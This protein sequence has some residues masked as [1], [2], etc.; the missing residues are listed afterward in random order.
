MPDRRVKKF[1]KKYE[2]ENKVIEDNRKMFSPTKSMKR[3]FSRKKA[4]ATEDADTVEEKPVSE[5][6]VEEP[7]VEEPPEEEP[8]A[9]D[10]VYVT[11]NESVDSP[12]DCF[13]PC[14]I[15]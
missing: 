1:I 4:K 11:E 9:E 8:P 15:M 12:N 3:L 2:S 5:E 14:A 13:A 6:P 7:V 10:P